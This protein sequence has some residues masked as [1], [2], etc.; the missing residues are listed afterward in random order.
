MYFLRHTQKFFSF[1]S[2][3]IIS[4]GKFLQLANKR[5][6][7]DPS[8]ESFFAKKVFLHTLIF[9]LLFSGKNTRKFPFVTCVHGKNRASNKTDT[10][11]AKA[12]AAAQLIWL[13]K[14]IYKFLPYIWYFHGNVC[15]LRWVWKIM[16][17]K[18]VHE[19]IHQTQNVIR[20]YDAIDRWLSG[21][22][23]LK[24]TPT[25]LGQIDWNLN[26]HPNR[27]HQL[28]IFPPPLITFTTRSQE[29]FEKNFIFPHLFKRLLNGGWW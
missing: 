26:F 5:Y 11:E 23:W 27:A 8:R 3:F 10:K 2:L 1:C 28:H 15:I 19:C 13:K 25:G 20:T 6:I 24:C 14:L 29:V 7:S 16:H 9:F 4:L 22:W 21:W 18:N 17:L 12:A